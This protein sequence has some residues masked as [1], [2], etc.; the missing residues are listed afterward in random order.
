VRGR[1]NRGADRSVKQRPR[2]RTV[3][4]VAFCHG[5]CSFASRLIAAL[6]GNRPARP[7]PHSWAE[8]SAHHSVE[9][10]PPGLLGAV[11]E[12]VEPAEEMKSWLNKEFQLF[13]L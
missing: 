13:F 12:L 6:A 5:L 4:H 10:E 8:A 9:P 11:R 2:Q 7:A 3:L 1:K